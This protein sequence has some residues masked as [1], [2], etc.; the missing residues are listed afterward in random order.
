MAEKSLQ[1]RSVKIEKMLP[2]CLVRGSC[3][4]VPTSLAESPRASGSHS[5][6]NRRYFCFSRPALLGVSRPHFKLYRERQYLAIFFSPSPSLWPCERHGASRRFFAWEIDFTTPV[7]STI[8]LKGSAIGRTSHTNFLSFMTGIG[9]RCTS[10]SDSIQSLQFPQHNGLSLNRIKGTCH[11]V[12]DLGPVRTRLS[13]SILTIRSLISVPT[14]ITRN[15]NCTACD[16][17]RSTRIRSVP[18]STKFHTPPMHA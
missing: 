4:A 18:R 9:R 14:G 17:C 15:S 2:G 3:A 11:V 10:L 6:L 16:S 8:P 5:N 12:E 7:A 1:P 13:N